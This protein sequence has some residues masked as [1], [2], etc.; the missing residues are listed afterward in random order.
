MRTARNESSTGYYH[1]MNRGINGLYIFKNKLEKQK[2][3]RIIREEKAKINIRMVAYCIM[4]NHFHFLIKAEK[5]DLTI[6]MKKI[7]IRYALYYNR[8]EKRRGPV[9]QDRFKSEAI[10][11]EAYLLSAIRYIHNNPVK[12]KMIE[13]FRN[14][15]WSSARQYIKEFLRKKENVCRENFK[16]IEEIELDRNEL[17][18]IK[19]RY[20]NL[21]TF[22]KNHLEEDFIVHL[23]IKKDMEE[24]KMEKAQM[25]IN[26][27]CETEGIV[28][29]PKNSSDKRHLKIKI[30]KLIIEKMYLSAREISELLEMPLKSV[31]RQKT[32]FNKRKGD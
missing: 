11:N 13:D 14:Y 30:C 17:S 10:E 7:G 27:V 15:E 23:D 20:G 5:E 21:E 6:Y 29:I 2:L 18:W 32:E 4:D 25:L 22:V 28:E 9:F 12:A 19:E 3:L 24:E 31:E 8:K 26:Q 1:I 16:N